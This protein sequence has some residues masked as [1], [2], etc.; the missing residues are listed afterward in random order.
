MVKVYQVK[1]RVK[2]KTKLEEQS[3]VNSKSKYRGSKMVKIDE[4]TF[5]N[6]EFYAK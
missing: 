5:S 4:N 2:V 3:K 6:N 1:V